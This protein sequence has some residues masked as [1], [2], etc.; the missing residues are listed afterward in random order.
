[1]LVIRQKTLDRSPAPVDDQ[2]TWSKGR[3]RCL[4]CPSR[5]DPERSHA[6]RGRGADLAG[7]SA[8]SALARIGLTIR[9]I[10]RKATV[11]R[12][13]DRRHW[14]KPIIGNE[15]SSAGASKQRIKNRPADGVVLWFSEPQLPALRY[16]SS[17]E[18]GSRPR[19]E[20]DAVGGSP[21]RTA[22]RLKYWIGVGAT[23]P[24]S[25]G[26]PEA[27]GSTFSSAR[28]QCSRFGC[29]DSST[30]APDL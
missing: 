28:Y 4:R 22:L 30:P 16:C 17:T 1:V 29:R 11:L 3:H 20:L 6:N 25:S 7:R 10:C 26:R 12:T 14:S 27:E 24:P 9:D 2:T 13:L 21:G 8:G 18:A 5:M 15:V 19:L 23:K